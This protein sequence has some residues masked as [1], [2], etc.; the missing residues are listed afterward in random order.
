L[1]ASTVEIETDLLLEDAT[2][3]RWNIDIMLDFCASVVAAI[4]AISKRNKVLARTRVE[5]SS[6]TYK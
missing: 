2:P 5:M 1:E 3:P 6:C 4:A